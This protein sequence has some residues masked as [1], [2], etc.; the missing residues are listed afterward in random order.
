MNI[1]HFRRSL[2]AAALL[3]A[4]SLTVPTIG[5]VAQADDKMPATD[6]SSPT[7]DTDGSGRTS[8]ADGSSRT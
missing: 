8:D 4:S 1:T 6:R 3:A 2:L 7:Y 5:G